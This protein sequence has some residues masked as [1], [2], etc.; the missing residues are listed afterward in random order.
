MRLVFL[1][2]LAAQLFYL[3]FKPFPRKEQKSFVE[4][5]AMNEFIHN[6]IKVM[7]G[8]Q[9][10]IGPFVRYIY[11]LYMEAG[12]YVEN[13]VLKV[14]EERAE[15]L[16]K[17]FY[18]DH[19]GNELPRPSVQGSISQGY[20][21]NFGF[22]LEK[23]EYLVIERVAFLFFQSVA[24]DSKRLDDWTAGK[25]WEGGKNPFERKMLLVADRDFRRYLEYTLE[26]DRI[27]PFTGEPLVPTAEYNFS[28]DFRSLLHTATE[29]L[30]TQAE[31]KE[32]KDKME[33]RKSGEKINIETL[34]FKKKEK[35]RDERILNPIREYLKAKYEKDGLKLYN[36]PHPFAFGTKERS[37]LKWGGR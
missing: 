6:R 36:F 22:N 19:E 7:L 20:S 10:A 5:E 15:A 34:S 9:A 33:A 17:R 11:N 4:P 18:T 21:A 28:L 3:F 29:Y 30:T 16:I 25:G 2:L 35:V 31:G 23:V 1:A 14:N 26:E 27:D 12:A 13:G 8:G 24:Q 32:F 37:R